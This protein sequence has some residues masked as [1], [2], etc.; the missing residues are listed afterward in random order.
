MKLEHQPLDSGLHVFTG[1]PM[2]VNAVALIDEGEAVVVD[3]TATVTQGREIRRFVEEEAEAQIVA[4][5]NTHWHS[6]HCGGNR[7]VL[8]GTTAPLIAQRLCRETLSREYG[9]IARRPAK[10]DFSAQLNP[11]LLV[12]RELTLRVGKRKLRL[13]HSPGHSPDSL[14]LFEPEERLAIVGDNLLA[15]SSPDKPALPYFFWG[16]PWKLVGVLERLREL[17]CRRIVPG[18]GAVLTG[19]QVEQALVG[20]LSYLRRLF[21][22]TADLPRIPL[23]ANADEPSP[24]WLEAVPLVELLPDSSPPPWV[25]RMHELNLLALQ[26]ND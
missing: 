11:Q 25:R 14:I 5:V 26:K 7:G 1:S 21:E 15:G 16:D 12:D 6:D 8:E 23:P 9:M 22:L 4:L 10:I 19:V 3:S 18:H 17:D 2:W 13:I 24:E 20:N